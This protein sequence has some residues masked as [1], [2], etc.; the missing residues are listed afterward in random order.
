MISVPRGCRSVVVVVLDRS[1][2]S[3]KE[4]H[5]FP[6]KDWDTSVDHTAVKKSDT[7]LK[8]PMVRQLK[9]LSTNVSMAQLNFSVHSDPKVHFVMPHDATATF[10]HIC[11][12]CKHN[13][14]ESFQSFHI[15]HGS[16]K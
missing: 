9:K 11:T 8:P 2:V 13:E 6:I 12:L 4:G 7:P 14:S 1:F 3:R 15:A 16:T 5:I 10:F